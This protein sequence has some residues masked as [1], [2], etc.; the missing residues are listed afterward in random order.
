MAVFD[1]IN[2]MLGVMSSLIDFFKMLD[3]IPSSFWG[4]VVGSFFSI[5]GVALT[6]RASDRRLSAQFEHELALKT[7]DR[8]MALRK[9]IYLAAVE[10]IAAGLDAISRFI[11][12]DLSSDE[13]TAAYVEKAPAIS[14][15]H[16]IA[17]T[18]TVKALLNFTSS[19]NSLYMTLVA[20][21]C[22]LQNDRNA[23]IMADNQIAGFGK[24][25]DRILEMIKQHNIEGIVDDRRW[26][27]LQENFEFE[28]KRIIECIARRDELAKTW[29][30]RHLE[31]MRECTAHAAKLDQLLIPVL[32]A[33]RAELELPLD[34]MVYRQV[35][36]AAFTSEQSAID[37]FIQKAMPNAAQPV[38]PPDT[39]Q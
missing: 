22:Q 30:P 26:K 29:Y 19:L 5:G 13:I 33:V 12:L 32:L 15:I 18:E 17:K 11:D 34:E 36:D 39:V 38:N 9:E 8:E 6:N 31:F 4:V 20:Q 1:G 16:V 37:T 24:E 27:V 14:K 7:K 10:A 21:R 3:A 25:R 23:I 35:A 28:Q 2:S